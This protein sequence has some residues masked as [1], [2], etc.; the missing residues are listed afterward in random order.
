MGRSRVLYQPESGR[1]KYGIVSCVGEKYGIVSAE[2]WW[3]EVGYCIS[4][5]V[6]GRSMVL[7]QPKSGGEKYGIVSTGEW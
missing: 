5:R 3:V 6:V 2:E 4:R 1:E 7:Y